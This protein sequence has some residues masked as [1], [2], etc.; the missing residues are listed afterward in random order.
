MYQAGELPK[1]LRVSKIHYEAPKTVCDTP[2]ASLFPPSME[3]GDGTRYLSDW[4]EQ[5]N[6]NKPQMD[7]PEMDV[8]SFLFPCF[9][10]G[11][12]ILGR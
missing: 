11:L 8:T 10:L 5:N 6:P 4:L 3:N 9:S 7:E 2:F 12:P 1:T